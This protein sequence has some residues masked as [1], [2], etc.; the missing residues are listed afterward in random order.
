MAL[1]VVG[2]VSVSCSL[3]LLMQDLMSRKNLGQ[4]KACEDK[5]KGARV[6]RIWSFTGKLESYVCE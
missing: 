2:L 4:G 1:S 5:L 6:N 3:L